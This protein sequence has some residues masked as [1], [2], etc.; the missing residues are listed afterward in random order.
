MTLILVVDDEA[1]IRRALERALVARGY[2]VDAAADGVEALDHAAVRL[3]DLIVLDLNMPVLGGLEVTRQIRG[4]SSVPILVLSVREDESDK[5][6]ALDSGADDYLTK[7]FSVGELLAR[8]RAL[9]R[10][11][12]TTGDRTP[13]VFRNGAVRI[14]MGARRVVRNGEDVHLTKTEWSLLEAF[15]GASGK[16]LTHRWLLEHVWGGGYEDDVE[17]LRVFVSQLRKKIEP[18]PHRPGAIVTEPGVGYRWSL[19]P[20]A[21]R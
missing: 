2:E 3:P 20:A 6:A 16:L 4:W 8:V 12:D 10:R 14:D 15:T 21:D 7:P 13:P 17:V 18:D 19:R 9:L 1:Q 5:I 11:T